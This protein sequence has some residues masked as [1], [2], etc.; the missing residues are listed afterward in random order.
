[1]KQLTP[2]DPMVWSFLAAV[3]CGVASTG[4]TAETPADAPP[5]TSAETSAPDPN[6]LAGPEVD[7]TISDPDRLTL[8]KR[9]FDGSIERIQGM[10]EV[11]ALDL[12]ELTDTVRTAIDDTL[13]ERG[14]TADRLAIDHI[15]LLD[16]IRGAMQQRPQ[17]QAERRERM[18]LF[19]DF[20]DAMEPLLDRGTMRDEIAGLLSED[21]RAT[22]LRVIAEYEE[23][24][25]AQRR[26]HAMPAMGMD[27]DRE[28]SERRQRMRERLGQRL[29]PNGALGMD[30][31]DFQALARE[32]GTSLR[33]IV[34]IAQRQLNAMLDA[35]DA[36]PE[37]RAEFQRVLQDF[38]NERAGADP[39][40]PIRR[41]PDQAIR[42]RLRDAVNILTPEQRQKLAEYMGGFVSR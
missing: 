42:A 2:W 32:L 30:R 21:T 27:D 3:S 12:F 39:D 37:Q 13:A 34:E 29:G 18:Q 6:I 20:R 40:D 17:S 11:A 16:Q 41:N 38:N 24:I 23:A 1:M 25:E 14:A 35:V 28:Q 9:D 26:G 33:G 31:R 36:T 5:D 22:Y 15:A 8:I 7:E 19:R 10:H 4:A